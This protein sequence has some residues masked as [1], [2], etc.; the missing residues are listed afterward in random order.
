MPAP[1]SKT[2]RILVCGAIPA[3]LLAACSTTPPAPPEFRSDAGLYRAVNRIG[4]GAT[5]AQLDEA[6]R[7]GWARY[8]DQQL[9]ADPKA[10]LPAAAQQQVDAMSISQRGMAELVQEVTELRKAQEV[11]VPTQMELQRRRQAYQAALNLPAR[12]AAERQVLRQLYS[13]QQLLEQTAWFWFNHFN[14]HQY[15]REVRVLLPDY[16]EHA[17]R[18]QALGSFRTLLGAVAR[19]PAMLRYLD[20]DQNGLNKPNE[21]YAR[22]LLEL[23]TMGVDGGYTQ[24]DVQELAR[25]LTGFS[26]RTDP[27]PP[28]FNARLAPLYV[29]EGLY[30]FNPARH[31]FGDKVL[32]GHTIKGRGAAELDEVLDLLV[33][34][35]A[36]ARFISHK[37]AVYF[38]AD[39]PPQAV[40]DRMAARF[41][42]THGDIAATLRELLLAPDFASA[43]LSKF[44]D[45]QHYLISGLRAVYGEQVIANGQPVQAW[46]RRLGQ[47]PYDK[48]TPDGYPQMAEAWNS[49]AQLTTRFELA[50]QIGAG[51]PALFKGMAAAPKPALADGALYRQTL[52]AQ[53][54]PATR[55]A[56]AE[57]G[58]NVPLWNALLLSAP[59][60]MLR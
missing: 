8:V 23:H 34:Q 36:T 15:K 9:K 31:D 55:S 1:N 29:R 20:N 35:P 3:L 7:A 18:P 13:Q 37:L 42:E 25:V 33:D 50:R 45:P 26:V 11:P 41:H 30:E 24:A 54:S 57:A 5:Q 39:Q 6:Q 49:P 46:L 52:Q 43:A 2:R 17:L 48:L 56:L 38:L 28:K 53:L 59:E 40:V 27:N 44:K 22:E 16:E 10:P 19:H 32:L 51:A 14:V 4:W 12:E 47:G 58:G 21:N 60:F